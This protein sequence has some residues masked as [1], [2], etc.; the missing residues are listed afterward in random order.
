MAASTKNEKG[1]A[2]IEALV[3]SFAIL[4]FVV[5]LMG[6]IYWAWFTN[7]LRFISHEFLICRQV[8]A[9]FSC[10]KNLKS[11]LKSIQRFGK[12]ADPQMTFTETY[13]QM[14]IHF[15]WGAIRWTFQDSLK[16]PITED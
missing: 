3:T 15:Q 1:Q 8:S 12:M 10:Q 6:A 7:N 2:T 5:S 13:S 14:K 16:I 11:R 4:S 9:S